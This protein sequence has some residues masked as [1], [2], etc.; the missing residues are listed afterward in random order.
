MKQHSAWLGFLFLVFA[1]CAAPAYAQLAAVPP[2][3]P[4]A[5]LNPGRYLIFQGSYVNEKGQ[6]ESGL[7]KFDSQTGLAWLLR[8]VPDSESKT[9]SGFCWVPVKNN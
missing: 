9:G 1:A 7:I 8:P 6:A 2:P 3:S 4:V 5:Y